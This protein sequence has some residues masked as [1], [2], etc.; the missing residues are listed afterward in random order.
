MQTVIGVE[1]I[2]LIRSTWFEMK[3]SLKYLI[4]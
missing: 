4:L 1:L 2:V 3:P